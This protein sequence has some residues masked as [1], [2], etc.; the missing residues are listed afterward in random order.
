MFAVKK[1]AGSHGSHTHKHTYTK[2]YTYAHIHIREHVH[3]H[4]HL[5]KQ[6]ESLNVLGTCAGRSKFVGG[7]SVRRIGSPGAPDVSPPP[8]PTPSGPRKV[9]I[10]GLDGRPVSCQLSTCA[11]ARGLQSSRISKPV[12]FFFA[13][14][15]LPRTGASDPKILWGPFASHEGPQCAPGEAA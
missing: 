7:D 12:I 2:R 10:L 5:H 11:F 14:T 8:P 4:V 9:P 1:L 6:Q 15:R 3:V 13:Y